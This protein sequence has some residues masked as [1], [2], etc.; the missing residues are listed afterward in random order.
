MRGALFKLE[1]II[2]LYIPFS[3]SRSDFLV[4]YH[5]I[6][7]SAI[8]KHVLIGY[9]MGCIMEH[10][11]ASQSTKERTR[12]EGAVLFS[13]WVFLGVAFVLDCLRYSVRFFYHFWLFL[14][15]HELFSLKFRLARFLA[16]S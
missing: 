16:S 6:K 14:S 10:P 3:C 12:G 2:T 11:C 15:V 1:L 8:I 4:F 9:E 7:K 5:V 13:F